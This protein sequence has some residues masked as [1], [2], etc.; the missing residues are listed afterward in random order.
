[1]HSHFAMGF[2][3]VPDEVNFKLFACQ[4]TSGMIYL[5]FVTIK[6]DSVVC[7]QRSDQPAHLHSL[8]NA[9]ITRF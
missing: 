1:M 4:R 7:E 2:V 3:A 5:D 8:N 9:F 6:P